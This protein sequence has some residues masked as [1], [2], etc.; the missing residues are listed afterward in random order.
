MLIKINVFCQELKGYN[1][2][3]LEVVSLYYDEVSMRIER[4]REDCYD[5]SNLQ[6]AGNV[7]PTPKRVHTSHITCTCE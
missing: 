3:F 6:A 4:C 1:F 2:Q 7:G 5:L